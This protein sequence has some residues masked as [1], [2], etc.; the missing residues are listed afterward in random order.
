VGTAGASAAA[1]R[2]ADLKVWTRGGNAGKRD[3][4]GPGWMRDVASTGKAYVAVGGRR[5]AKPAKPAAPGAVPAELPAVWTSADGLKWTAV[6]PP[7]LPQGLASGAFTQVVARGDALV[8]LGSGR[9]AAAA[10]APARA[11]AFYAHSAD[12]GR[13]WRTGG[14]PAGTPAGAALTAVTATAKGFLLAGATGEAGRQDVA[15]WTSPDGS[16]W[17]RLAASGTGLDGPG[18]QRLTAL[19]SVGGQV[20][21]TGTSTG[22]RGEVPMLWRTP[23]P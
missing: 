19:A 4:D 8:A 3:L 15:L 1:W 16:G 20:V 17:R 11:L 6:A 5:P 22:H 2:S 10:N 12:G 13:T 14:V 9:T 23:A 21:G 18:D 7:A